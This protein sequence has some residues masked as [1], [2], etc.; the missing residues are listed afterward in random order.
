MQQAE[1]LKKQDIDQV[2]KAKLMKAPIHITYDMFLN[3]MSV[4]LKVAL[5]DNDL[6]AAFKLLDKDKSGSLDA[7]EFRNVLQNLGTSF[8]EDEIE[9]M[10]R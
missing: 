4:R 7:D 8:T 6:K 10:I 3:I 9:E 5:S 2:E 1:D